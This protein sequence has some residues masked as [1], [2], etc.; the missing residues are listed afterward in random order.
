MR[1]GGLK[2]ILFFLLL[3]IYLYNPIFQIFNFGLIK[4]LLLIALFYIL[5][6]KRLNFFVTLFKR[7]ILFTLTLIVYSFIMTQIGD[8]SAVKVPYMH[9]IWFLEC[10]FIPVFFLGFFKD[11]FKKISGEGV[12]VFIGFIA[13][14]ITFFLILNP[15]TNSLIKNSILID[16]FTNTDNYNL[17]LTDTTTGIVDETRLFRGFTI[18]E[19]STYSYGIIQGIILSICLISYNK[20]KL[21]AIPIPFLIISILFNA[22][23]GIAIVI[24][25]ILLLLIT[26]KISIIGTVWVI[27]TLSV[28]YLL[29]L[30]TSFFINNEQT[31]RWALSIFDSTINLDLNDQ[32]TNYGVLVTML[33]FPST[34]FGIIF[35]E[36][37]VAGV[38][39]GFINQL[40]VGGIVYLSILLLF[41]WYIFKRNLKYSTNKLIPVIFLISIIIANFKGNALILPNGFFRLIT[42]YYIYCLY[43]YNKT[44]TLYSYL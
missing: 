43:T 17:F 10:F 39:I 20:N 4:L 5:V 23:I 40:F 13:S 15:S 36:G 37:K 9:T 11:V 32:N 18:A 3:Y 29:L 12:L 31:I 14:L 38:D 34:L 19:S 44:S 35:G 33:I 6:T 25:V 42:F 30:N 24:L 28:F 8:G 2:Y 7:E 22:R 26:K 16:P 41:L 1:K 21:Y 27:F